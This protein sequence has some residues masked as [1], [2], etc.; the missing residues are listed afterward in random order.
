MSPFSRDAPEGE[1]PRPPP[2]GGGHC[3]VS[4]GPTAGVPSFHGL[5]AG[6]DFLP[7]GGR[8]RSIRPR[9]GDR[10]RSFPGLAAGFDHPCLAARAVRYSGLEAGIA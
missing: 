9:P 8:R 10:G 7:P 6:L 1:G 2:P 5:A 3:P 4:P